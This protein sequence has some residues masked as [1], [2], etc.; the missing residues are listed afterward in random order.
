MVCGGQVLP[1]SGKTRPAA[2]AAPMSAIGDILHGG[3]PLEIVDES[4]LILLASLR[5]WTACSTTTL[6]EEQQ[7]TGRWRR[8]VEA[9]GKKVGSIAFEG[10]GPLTLD[11]DGPRRPRGGVA[12][13][14]GLREGAQGSLAGKETWRL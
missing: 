9:R 4:A 5:T 2:I 11:L 1:G 8:E 13:R 7:M 3:Y 12:D 14:P 6:A 10:D